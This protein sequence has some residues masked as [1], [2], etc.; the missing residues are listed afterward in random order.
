M[1][2]APSDSTHP[3]LRGEFVLYTIG[4]LL[5]GLLIGFY[6]GG[7]GTPVVATTIPLLF[8]IIGGAGG[9]YI[10]TADLEATTDR[11]RIGV[12]GACFIVFSIGA[13]IGTLSGASVR[14]GSSLPAVIGL[15]S[16]DNVTAIGRA[17]RASEALALGLLDARARALG[18]GAADRTAMLERAQ[19]ELTE[20]RFGLSDGQIRAVVDKVEELV[21]VVKEAEAEGVENKYV[22]SDEFVWQASL[23]GGMKTDGEEF[24][25]YGQLIYLEQINRTVRDLVN[26]PAIAEIPTPQRAKL[27]ELYNVTMEAKEWLTNVNWATSSILLDSVDEFVRNTSNGTKP[28]DLGLPVLVDRDR[29]D[30]SPGAL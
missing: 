12:L 26:N 28:A 2:G 13:L 14:T 23:L 21:A 18:I 4:L 15:S 8:A 27:V 30:R 9:F 24:L 17:P 25:R 16:S 3:Q 6:A 29:E 1:T 22:P 10:A 19:E 20:K 11:R 7:S 5:F